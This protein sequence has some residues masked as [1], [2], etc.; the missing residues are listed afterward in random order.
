[1]NDRIVAKVVDQGN[2][3]FRLGVVGQ[4]EVARWKEILS[5]ACG[6][7]VVEL[8]EREDIVGV[9]ELKESEVFAQADAYL[10]SL[11]EPEPVC[12]LEPDVAWDDSVCGTIE[13]RIMA[14]LYEPE[15]GRSG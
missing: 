3:C 14:R 15:G 13:Q 12:P 10:A 9:D 5:S 1:M 11:E 4:D 6:V 7:E 2:G 8:D